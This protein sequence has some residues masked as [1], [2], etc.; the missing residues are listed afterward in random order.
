[1]IVQY[2]PLFII[3]TI[4][5]NQI[6]TKNN[7]KLLLHYLNSF[8]DYELNKAIIRP[9][10]TTFLCFKPNLV[11]VKD[12][13]RTLFNFIFIYFNWFISMNKKKIYFIIG[14]IILLK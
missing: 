7:I 3:H 13:T 1:M 4:K 14:N 5:N 11:K 8:N 2:E 9:M 12:F 6:Y 10:F